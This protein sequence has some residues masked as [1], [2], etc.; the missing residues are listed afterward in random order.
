MDLAYFDLYDVRLVAIGLLIGFSLGSLTGW[1][2]AWRAKPVQ[3]VEKTSIPVV[4]WS[5]KGRPRC[6]PDGF[7]QKVPL[8]KSIYKVTCRNCLKIYNRGK[9]KTRV[10]NRVL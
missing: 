5:A 7:K 3:F 2:A 6:N 8:S 10:A 9:G 1:I 4:H